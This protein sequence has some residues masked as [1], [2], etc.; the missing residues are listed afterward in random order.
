MYTLKKYTIADKY[1]LLLTAI[2][3][4]LNVQTSFMCSGDAHDPVKDNIESRRPLL[5]FGGGGAPHQVSRTPCSCRLV[6]CVHTTCII[7]PR[8]VKLNKSLL[9]RLTLCLHVIS[10]ETNRTRPRSCSHFQVVLCDSC[11]SRL[12][13]RFMHR[14]SK[15]VRSSSCQIFFS[16]V[17]QQTH[18]HQKHTL[19][20]LQIDSYVHDKKPKCHRLPF[21]CVSVFDTTCDLDELRLKPLLMNIFSCRSEHMWPRLLTPC[22]VNEL[23]TQVSRGET[24]TTELWLLN[25]DETIMRNHK[26]PD[27]KINTNNSELVKFKS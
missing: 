14:C 12:S 1:L 27:R 4:L 8:V 3:T 19:Q 17:P 18:T 26:W 23:E 5:K 10:T 25:Y 24:I 15:A 21:I 20:N 16:S 6:L 11:I 2:A 9:W 7:R 13:D 22:G